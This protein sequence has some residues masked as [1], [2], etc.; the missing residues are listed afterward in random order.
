[1]SEAPSL[2]RRAERQTD[3]PP[4]NLPWPGPDDDT[5]VVDTT[6]GHLQP[7][8]P[9]AGVR[10]VGEVEVLDLLGRGAMLIDTRVADSRSGF[11]L[12]GAQH[13]PH[14]RIENLV[15]PDDDDT[16]QILFCNG[17]QCGQ[18]PDA[19]RTLAGMS[20]PLDRLAYYRGGLHDWI[21][22]GLPAERLP[23][24]GTAG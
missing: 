19:L 14:D 13:V 8:T 10:T 20:W 17:P 7:H 24:N 21:T 16:V 3:Q 11:T 18:T 6:W 1:M 12:P 5:V 2:P 22:L 15:L 23:A 4:R 9:V